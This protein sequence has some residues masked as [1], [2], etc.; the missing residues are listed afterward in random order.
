VPAE[1]RRND[2]WR[3]CAQAQ[4][5]V[6]VELTGLRRYQIVRERRVGDIGQWLVI[7]GINSAVRHEVVGDGECVVD[8]FNQTNG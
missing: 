6:L 2:G 5:A 4:A 3:Y 7:L 1:Q 8:A